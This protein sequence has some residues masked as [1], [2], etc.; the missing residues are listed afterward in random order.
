M[1]YLLV[2]LI[3]ALYCAIHH[4]SLVRARLTWARLGQKVTSPAT[5]LSLSFFPILLDLFV[6]IL[7]FTLAGLKA[8]YAGL[9]F[10]ILA[11]STIWYQKEW[12]HR[13]S[14]FMVAWMTNG[15][16]KVVFVLGPLALWLAVGI[17]V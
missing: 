5:V 4:F 12:M 7:L 9:G 3:L 17:K 15:V 16:A 1:N 8:W 6:L 11:S 14:L 13:R 10:V 2:A